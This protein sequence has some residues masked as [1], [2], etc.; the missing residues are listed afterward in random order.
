MVPGTTNPTAAGGMEPR[1]KRA[2]LLSA[3]QGRRLL[4]LTADRPKCAL[5]FR[6]R[7]FVEWQIDALFD[8]GIEDVTVVLGYG[9][10]LVERLLG[11]RYAGAAVRTLYNPFYRLADNLATCWSARAAMDD[12]F[13]LI[14]GDT[15]FEVD[16]VR[17]LVAG[18]TA[19]ITVTIDH[20]DAYDADDMKVIRDGAGRPRRIGKQLPAEEV[21]AEAIGLT[22]FTG[23]GPV[24]FKE[25]VAR[26]LRRDDG[27]SL[28]YPSVLDELARTGEVA[29]WSVGSRRWSEM[30]DHDDLAAVEAVAAA[31]EGAQAADNVCG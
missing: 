9:V 8:A 19:P 27:L 11:E 31:L 23:T 7:T 1:L 16:I 24:L 22:A 26:A 20:K 5:E 29:A 18:A 3:G 30:D 25:A 2:V 12:D 21:S 6:G 28:W 14:N 15:L 4:P 17:H 10:D 13:L